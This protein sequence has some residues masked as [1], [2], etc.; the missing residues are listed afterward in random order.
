MRR[1]N[2]DYVAA[3]LL[4]TVASH[5]TTSAVRNCEEALVIHRCIVLALPHLSAARIIAHSTICSGVGSY[6]PIGRPP[7]Q[8]RVAAS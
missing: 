5:E 8:V 2:R 6:S 4:H 1:L 7:F 3:I